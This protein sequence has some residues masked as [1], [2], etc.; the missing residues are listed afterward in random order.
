M[1]ATKGKAMIIKEK[2][3]L[4]T[5]Y[6]ASRQAAREYDEAWAEAEAARLRMGVKRDKLLS[7][8]NA[9]AEANN[10]AFISYQQG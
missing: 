7:A 3:T 6:Y 4:D 10:A 1:S 8:H 2:A 9:F 5:L